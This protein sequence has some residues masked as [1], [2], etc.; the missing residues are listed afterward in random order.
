MGPPSHVPLPK[1]AFS[2]AVVPTLATHVADCGCTG[3]ADTSACQNESA[4][5]MGQA[6]APGRGVAWPGV[7]CRR[8][9]ATARV[10]TIVPARSASAL[11]ARA[12]RQ[13][14]REP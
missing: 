14:A 3:S 1:S 7:P 8:L 2:L 13:M 10:T 5:V 9:A 12:Y 4:G 11:H 6:G